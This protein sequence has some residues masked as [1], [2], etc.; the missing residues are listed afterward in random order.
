MSKS[1]N[2]LKK[3][4]IIGTANFD[5]KYGLGKSKFN[6][7]EFLK[8]IKYLKKN[9]I[10]QIDWSFDYSDS[11]QLIK[12]IEKENILIDTKV[13]FE[14]I[15]EYT[16]KINYL[17]LYSIKFNTVYIRSPENTTYNDFSYVYNLLSDL[18]KY[19]L[20]KKIGYSIYDIEK[21]NKKNLPVPDVLQLPLNIF[22]QRFLNSPYRLKCR[23]YK[24]EIV[25]RSIFLQGKLLNSNFFKSNK[26]EDYFFYKLDCFLKNNNLSPLG[27]I[28]TFL[29]S[30]DDLNSMIIGIDSITHLDMFMKENILKLSPS[31]FKSFSIKKKSII[32]PR[33][34]KRS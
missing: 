9:K 33:L 31:L 14:K 7:Y 11:F 17:N 20:I 6:S 1:S 15:Y 23:K 5:Y 28:K 29:N 4:I 13:S 19:K 10:N 2:K 27:F 34:W 18:K 16:N 26:A 21:L 24:T 30:I 12:K 3:N 8:L 25:A 22:D 32:D